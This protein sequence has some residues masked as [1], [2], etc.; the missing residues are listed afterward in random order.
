MAD[1]PTTPLFDARAPGVGDPL[2][3]I[4]ETYPTKNRGT[5]PRYGENFMILSLTVFV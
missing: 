4:D 5:G 1:F 3:F 2:E